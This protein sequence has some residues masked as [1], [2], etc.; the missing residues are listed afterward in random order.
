VSAS[1]S[2]EVVERIVVP[3]REGGSAE[4]KAGERFRVV[5]LEGSQCVDF[6]AL[7][8]D[9][10][11]EYM[12]ASHTR[13]YLYRLFPRLGEPFV[14]N[15]RRPILTYEEDTSPGVHD[16]L[17]APCDPT[18]YEGLGVEG[19]HANC[20]DTFYKIVDELG[21]GRLEMPQS[22]NLF[23]NIPIKPD[24]EMIWDPAPSKAGDYIG[25]KAA[26]DCNIVVSACP[27]DI[28]PINSQNPTSIAIELLG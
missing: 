11:A 28:L 1:D 8:S 4:V 15:R 2:T 14:T 20:Q 10:I 23:T 3:A 22:V 12:S 17:I 7:C 24:G 19:W 6:W 16:M 18:R 25:F 21:K 26:L 13:V 5:D 27:Q 9:D